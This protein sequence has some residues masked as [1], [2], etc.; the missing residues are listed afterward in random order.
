MQKRKA[1]DKLHVERPKDGRR[2]ECRRQRQAE[3]LKSNGPW[4]I[5]AVSAWL[6]EKKEGAIEMKTFKEHRNCEGP[7]V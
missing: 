1:A 2:I 7:V 6:E 3:S 5:C 4:S